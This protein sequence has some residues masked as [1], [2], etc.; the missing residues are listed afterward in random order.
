MNIHVGRLEDMGQRFVDAFQRAQAGEAVDERHIT[1][2]SL[3]EMMSAL[4]PRR[5]E[6][7]RQL[8]REE[9]ASVKALARAL[10]RDYKRVHEDVKTLEAAGL[11]VREDGRIG[12]PWAAL[13]AEV[14][15]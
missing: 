14:A 8:R 15:L 12:V 4:T 2:P 3:E 11:I 9:V 13:A 7:L 6:L 10:G 1:F 5:L